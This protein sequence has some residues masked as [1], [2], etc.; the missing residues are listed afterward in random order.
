MVAQKS[1]DAVPDNS[2]HGNR[3]GKK[4]KNM[5]IFQTFL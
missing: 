4:G 1:L 5:V 3:P 2:S